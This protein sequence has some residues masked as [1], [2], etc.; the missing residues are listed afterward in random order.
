MKRLATI[1]AV[2]VV[3]ALASVAHAR[4]AAQSF[5]INELINVRRVSDPQVSPD[6]NWI[7]YTIADTDKAANKRTTQSY[8]GP[9]EGGEPRALTSGDKSSNS[10]RWSPDGKRIAY[11]SA[12]DGQVWVMNA[13]G[14]APRKV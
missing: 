2:S 9:I 12:R 5:T 6:G 3:L 8:R 7:A 13:E 11:I 4:Q 14:S 1:A 10:P